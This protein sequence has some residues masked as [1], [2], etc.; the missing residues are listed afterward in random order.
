MTKV[1]KEWNISPSAK[2]QSKKKA[3]AFCFPPPPPNPP[4]SLAPLLRAEI[5]VGWI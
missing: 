5:L 3:P 1:L 2:A 4:V